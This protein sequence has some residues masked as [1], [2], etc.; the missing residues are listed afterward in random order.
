MF[1]FELFAL[2]MHQI[3]TSA[4]V[5]VSRV[6]LSKK[7]TLFDW[8]PLSMGNDGSETTSDHQPMIT[9]AAFL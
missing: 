2:K 6:S 1:S 4:Q 7:V 8:Y 3:L 5:M 9:A